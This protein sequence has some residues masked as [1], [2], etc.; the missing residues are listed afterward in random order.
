MLVLGSATG[1]AAPQLVSVSPPDGAASVGAATPVVFTFSEAMS[2]S[3][4]LAMFTDAEDEPV[5]ALPAW[6]AG[7]KVLTYTPYPAWPA[8]ATVNWQ[9]VLAVSATS[10]PMSSLP[11]GSFSTGEGGGSSGSGTNAITELS[12][13]RSL[14]YNQYTPGAP[15]PDTNY[16]YSF[17][18]SAILASNR[19]ATAI[20]LAMP[21]PASTISNLAANFFRPELWMMMYFTTNQADFDAKFPASGAYQFSIQNADSN[22]LVSASLPAAQPPAPQVTSSSFTAARSVNPAQPFTL[23]WNAFS[24]GGANDYIRVNIGDWASPELGASGAL[25]GLAT[26]VVVPAGTLEAASH[27]E[28]TITFYRWVG[29]SNA[30]YS[31][32][33]YKAATTQFSVI[34]AGG[35][36]APAFAKWSKSGNTFAAEI[37]FTAGQTVTV[38]SSGNP[39]APLAQWQPLLTTNAPGTVFRF[40]DSRAGVNGALFYRARNGN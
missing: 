3:M 11:A 36:E 15:V 37:T 39:A 20:S 25:N 17:V 38:L 26:S 28:A 33:A 40:T 21:A 2:T 29:T 32:G 19:T 4:T 27:Y 24:G 13:G 5:A 23:A 18:A 12:F 16:A 1:G 6:S 7:N 9:F 22:Q 10:I 34:T 14:S 30:N 8:N 31:I 35:A